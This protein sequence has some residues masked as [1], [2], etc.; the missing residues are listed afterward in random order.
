MNRILNLIKMVGVKSTINA[1]FNNV[2]NI[3]VDNN[4]DALFDTLELYIEVD[5]GFNN[6]ETFGYKKEE[7]RTLLKAMKNSWFED[8]NSLYLTT[9]IF[10]PFDDYL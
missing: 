8:R 6:G 5:R 9:G 3:H 2:F 7:L 4:I 10:V 1:I